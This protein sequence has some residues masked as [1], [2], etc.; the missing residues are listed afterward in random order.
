MI[1]IVILG[2]GH[3]AERIATGIHYSKGK[4]YGIASRDR[5]K[6]SSFAQ[7]YHIDHIFS[8]EEAFKDPAVDLI[9]IATA[10]PTHTA[11]GKEALSHHKHVIIEKPLAANCQ[12]IKALFETA[13][14]HHCFLMEAHKTCFTPLQQIIRK[15]VCE[16]GPL[17]A[18][19][20]KYCASFDE[21]ALKEWNVEESMG[22]SF[23]DVGVYPI[24]FS[25]LYAQ[26]DIKQMSFHVKPYKDY[27]CD[28]ECECTIEYE[29]GI[30]SSLKSS[31]LEKEENK[32]ILIGEKGR[33]EII[34]Y[35]KN[36]QARIMISD[37]E[38]IIRVDQKSDFTGEIDHALDCIQKGL[39]QSPLMSE[40]FSLQIS[41]V[42]EE[43]KCQRKK[44]L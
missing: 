41:Q 20:A 9:Y 8:Y 25:H 33:I 6:A 34:D 26:S 15:R 38:E 29:N 44:A 3:I 22:G 2:C 12:D 4:L 16:I 1:N 7:K 19:S 30:L 24:C 17:H 28:F 43:M 11:L 5:Q 39:L 32:G 42:L 35:W 40:K 13:A 31:W 18:I 21:N 36:T 23:Y 14:R 27:P 37:Q 10:N